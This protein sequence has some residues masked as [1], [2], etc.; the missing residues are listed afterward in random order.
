VAAHVASSAELIEAV[1]STIRP[2]DAVMIKGSLSMK[3]ALIVKAIKE[4]YGAGSSAA[5]LKG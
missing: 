4:Q 5:A 2:G 1:C 3:M